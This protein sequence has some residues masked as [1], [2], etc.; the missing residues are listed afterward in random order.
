MV[1]ITKTVIVAKPV[2]R[3]V[4]QEIRETSC[5][6]CLT[7]CAGDTFAITKAF[8]LPGHTCCKTYVDA[9]QQPYS[10]IVRCG[11][12]LNRCGY[13]AWNSPDYQAPNEANSPLF[14]F[15]VIAE[16]QSVRHNT[17]D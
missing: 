14:C 16:H 8:F 5:L 10:G 3:R 7:N 15:F 17:T 2:S 1:A 13:V 4:A 11:H 6:T 9:Q 12:F